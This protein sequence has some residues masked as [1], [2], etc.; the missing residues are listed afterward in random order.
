MKPRKFKIPQQNL[1]FTSDPDLNKIFI[2]LIDLRD[3]STYGA[4]YK[5]GWEQA[6]LFSDLVNEKQ[7][8]IRNFK[9]LG[10]YKARM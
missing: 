1:L 2:N 9:K 5:E 3:L 6:Q 4:I 10:S 8:S 7:V